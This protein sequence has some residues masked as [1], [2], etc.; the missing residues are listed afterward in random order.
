MKKQS[1]R[2]IILLAFFSVAG[3]IITQVFWIN[4]AF[5]LADN[6]FDNRVTI[7]LQGALDEYVQ[8]KDP[9]GFNPRTGCLAV[10][11]N[12]DSL[13]INLVPGEMDSLLKVHFEYHGLD[14]LFS[15]SVV[16]CATDEVLFSKNPFTEEPKNASRHR[17]SLS[18]LHHEESH[19]LMVVFDSKN[20][21]LL[22]DMIIWLIASFAFLLIVA[23]VFSFIVLSIIKQK[24][25]A[26]IRNDFVNNM[27]HEFKTPISNISLASEVLIRKETL[28][29][30]D[31]INQYARIISEENQRMRSQVERILQ[32]AVRNREDMTI[33]RE[34]SDLHQLIREAVDSICFPECNSNA[35]IRLDFRAEQ[36]V[37]EVDPMHFSN[38][39]HNLLD[40]AQKYSSASPLVII[41]TK[42]KGNHFY[43]EIEDNGIGISSE[44]QKHIFDKFYRVPTGNLHNVKGFGL[45]LYYVKY[46]IEKHG[47]KISVKSELGKGTIFRLELPM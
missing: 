16:K 11:E 3:L 4:N 35:R 24:K 18:C 17:I 22:K 5:K 44:A 40:N 46:M 45:G 36:S 10:S 30:P 14:T 38:I 28:S 13:F 26:E 34:S 19:H 25:I 33:H 31:R 29:N 32:V 47:G 39:L 2:L 23:M 7:A 12:A 6:Q 1:I 42:I 41:R 37:L 9:S 21:I 15:F 43:I 27:T 8:S 20:R